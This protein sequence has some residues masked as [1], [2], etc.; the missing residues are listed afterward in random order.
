MRIQITDR[1]FYFSQHYIQLRDLNRIL[2]GDSKRTLGEEQ[3]TFVHVL[4]D[5]V[6][7]CRRKF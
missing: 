7:L 5:S 1:M 6:N 2:F 3:Q 4:R